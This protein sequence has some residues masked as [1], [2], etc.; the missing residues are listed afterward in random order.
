MTKENLFLSSLQQL[1]LCYIAIML[2]IAQAIAHESWGNKNY[3]YYK[4][5]SKELQV[6]KQKLTFI[7]DKTIDLEA[8]QKAAKH[9][10][11]Q[12]L[13]E[14][15]VYAIINGLENINSYFIE[16]NRSVY[17][18]GQNYYISTSSGESKA[19]YNNYNSSNFVIYT[20]VHSF[21]AYKSKVDQKD[22][23]IFLIAMRGLQEIIKTASP[24]ET[25]LIILYLNHRSYIV[26]DLTLFALAVEVNEGRKIPVATPDLVGLLQE[27]S[28]VRRRVTHLLE[29]MGPAVVPFLIK[30]LEDE[31]NS[32]IQEGAFDVLIKVDPNSLIPVLY[33]VLSD[34]KLKIEKREFAAKKLGEL[35]PR[36]YKAI[37]G[38]IN[39]SDVMKK[40]VSKEVSDSALR[41]QI[42]GAAAVVLNMRR[43]QGLNQRSPGIMPYPEREH[44]FIDV[45]G[46][47]Y[48]LHV[49]EGYS[50]IVSVELNGNEYSVHNVVQSPVV[51]EKVEVNPAFE[52]LRKITGQDFGDE[53]QKWQ[54]WWEENRDKLKDKVESNNIRVP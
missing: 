25:K 45:L 1:L 32:W 26:V 5:P 34:T 28:N 54:D 51:Y 41:S 46:N 13:V 48:L 39:F 6:Q 16:K 29:N 4:E 20:P 9:R 30:A 21:L 2:T 24:E 14:S 10:E 8:V 11:L 18:P 7:K 37:P 40:T 15:G 19:H 36:A 52:A 38:L 49:S 44:H 53:K 22:F 47:E 42:I 12:F 33:K 27:S 43:I 50:T 31:K 17:R 3:N 23:E 35:G